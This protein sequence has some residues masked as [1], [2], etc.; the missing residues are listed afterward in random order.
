MQCEK[1]RLIDLHAQF[2]DPMACDA[3]IGNWLAEGGARQG[4]PAQRFQRTLC[5]PNRAHAVMDTP[6]S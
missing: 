4:A 1:P 3:L 2:R 5:E 6:R